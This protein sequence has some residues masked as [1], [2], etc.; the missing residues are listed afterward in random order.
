MV[1]INQSWTLLC[2]TMPPRVP[3]KALMKSYEKLDASWLWR[4]RD[5]GRTRC[6]MEDGSDAWKGDETGMQ[7]DGGEGRRENACSESER[8]IGGK[9]AQEAMGPNNLGSLC[10]ARVC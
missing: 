7:M 4:E 8:W 5:G 3:G 2:Y 6:E 10:K 9:K 1:T